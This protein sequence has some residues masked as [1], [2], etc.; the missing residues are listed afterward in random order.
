MNRID[1]EVKK[2][3]AHEEWKVEHM[4]S[5]LWYQDIKREG[6]A[7]GRAEGRIQQLFD[8]VIEGDLPLDKAV[9]KSL[10]PREEFLKQMEEYNKAKNL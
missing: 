6:R 7:E 5:Y 4:T 8:L 1:Q 2:A 10:L 3:R 9:Q